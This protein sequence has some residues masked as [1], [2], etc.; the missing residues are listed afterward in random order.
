MRRTIASQLVG[1]ETARF[2]SLTLEEFPKESTRRTPV[3]PG[4]HQDIDQVTI[5]IHRAPQILALTMDPH[6]HFVQ[7][8]RISES[9]LTSLQPPCVVGP[10]R[11]TPVP[12][13]L[14]GDRDT[15]LSKQVLDIAETQAEPVVEPDGV[16]DDLGWES[17]SVRAGRMTPHRSTLPAVAST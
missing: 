15:P 12:N 17:V 1:H 11:L 3:S 2:Q 14:L 5:L 9:T 6:E 7:E 10:E 4:L 8:P 16:T 13:R